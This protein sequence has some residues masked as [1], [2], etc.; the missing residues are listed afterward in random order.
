MSF[1]SSISDLTPPTPRRRMPT[2]AQLIAYAICLG[3][4][5]MFLVVGTRQFF[6]Q[7]TLLSN[8]EQIEVEITRSEVVVS[9]T[10]DTDRRLN[11]DNSTTTYRPEVEFTYLDRGVRYKSDRLY[12][13]IIMRTFAGHDSAAEVLAPY[14]VGTKVKAHINRAMPDKAYLIAERGAGPVVFMSLG[15]L[16]LPI[17]WLVG[18]IV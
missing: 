13:T 7:R 11:R 3:F 10:E 12:P 14:R 16:L 8:A 1:P 4:A 18:K 15:V 9:K 17:A 5:G 2:I 6:E